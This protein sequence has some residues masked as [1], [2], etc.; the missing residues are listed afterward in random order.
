M[1]NNI[2]NFWIII[3]LYFSIVQIQTKSQIGNIAFSKFGNNS[4]S[5]NFLIIFL[6]I[7]RLETITMIFFH[8]K[9]FIRTNIWMSP[10]QTIPWTWRRTSFCFSIFCVVPYDFRTIT[11]GEC[12]FFKTSI[13]A[14][15]A[16][17]VSE[18]AKVGLKA[19]KGVVKPGKKWRPY[20]S[21]R[22]IIMPLTRWWCTLPGESFRAG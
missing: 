6:I 8:R 17:S 22:P 21:A 10:G 16:L 19:N 18:P 4:G 1:L 14:R 5:D 13:G 11:S 7:I 15:R 20:L 2:F 12:S 9:S 3:Q